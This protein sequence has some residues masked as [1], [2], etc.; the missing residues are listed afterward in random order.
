[1][2]KRIIRQLNYG[3]LVGI[4][5]LG[6]CGGLGMPF[7]EDNPSVP[8][9]AVPPPPAPPPPSPTA[10]PSGDGSENNGQWA[11][12]YKE[13]QQVEKVPPASPTVIA[14]LNQAQNKE[15]AGQLNEAAAALERAMRVEPRNGILWY[16]LALLRLKQQKPKEAIQLA[17]KS[18]SLSKNNKRV[19]ASDW[20]II[21]EARLRLGDKAGAEKAL[22]KARE[23][24]ADL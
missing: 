13:N 18:I 1:M 22:N 12:T 11:N 7:P 8:I 16:R 6:G 20:R 15:Q 21:Y 24:G 2:G 17:L 23:F 3:W 9:I 5:F 4:V 19:V 14:L 10:P